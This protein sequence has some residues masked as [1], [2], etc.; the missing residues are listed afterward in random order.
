MRT[1]PEIEARWWHPR[2]LLPRSGVLGSRSEEA[3]GSEQNL[4]TYDLHVFIYI[5][6]CMYMYIF[7]YIYI[8]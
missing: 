1:R 4:N 7:M 8:C 5:Y 6:I 3:R 2:S